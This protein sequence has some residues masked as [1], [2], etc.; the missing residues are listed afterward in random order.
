[1]NSKSAIR[2]TK[3][4]GGIVA[5]FQQALTVLILWG[6]LL[7]AHA[8]LPAD[9]PRIVV[10]NYNPSAVSPGCVFL[11]VA[12]ELP[13]VGAYLMIVTNNGNIVWYEKLAVPGFTISRCCP[14]VT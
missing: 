5:V 9:F 13:G 14:M 6:V 2:W 4:Q 12:S 3:S 10:S 7:K 8:Q 11:A 1:M